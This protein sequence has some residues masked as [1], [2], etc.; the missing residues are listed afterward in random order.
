VAVDGTAATA[1]TG[2]LART[3]GETVSG[4]PYAITQGTLAASSNYTIT[5][6]GSTFAIT[7]ATLLI[8]AQP[9]TKV[10]GSADP[11]LAYASSG[12]QFSDTAATVLTGSPAREAGETVSDSPYAIGQG[13]LTANSNYTIQFTGSTLTVTPATPAVTVSDPGGT[14]TSAP[15]AAMATV[16]G[17][18]GTATPELEGVKPTLTYYTGS[19]TSG[20]ALGSAAPSAA[21]TYTV[22]AR[23][24]G[25]ADYSAAQSKPA[26]FVIA[27]AVATV[28]LTSQ[29]GSPVYGQAVTFVAT[30]NSA[31]GAPGGT[32]TFADGTAPLATVPL[33]GSGQAG[34]TISTLSL[35]A[36]AIT[37]TYNGGT[38]TIGG[39][40]GTAA[41][42]VSPAATAIVLEPH[43][44]LKGKKTLKAVE[45]TAAIEPVAPGRGVPM[46]TVTFE[47]V[48][49]QR[50]KVKVT[51][52]G[53]AT[54][55]D[56]AATLT[57]EPNKVLN[58]PLLI[59]YS[60]DPDF[61]ASTMSPPKLKRSSISAANA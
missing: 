44:L 35:G 60:G 4:G 47:F 57:F 3:P 14:Y 59:V 20:V 12:F 42:S 55:S 50:K 52:L 23:F 40:S 9:Q 8:V 2:H 6:T 7:P 53:T 17:V 28:V 19:G 51:R 15:I 54:L 39:K 46:G 5:F 21:G 16:T 43:A 10:F 36:H 24:P 13:T 30:V 45:L 32:V 49:K 37:A 33:N 22:V 25:S 18:G 38:D 1:L 56:G 27:P 41:E 58:K 34:L 11:T 61:L 48:T 26:T 29:S 31:G